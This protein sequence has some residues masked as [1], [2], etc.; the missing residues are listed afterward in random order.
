MSRL[1]LCGGPDPS[2]GDASDVGCVPLAEVVPFAYPADSTSVSTIVLCW[3][4]RRVS[5]RVAEVEA[6]CRDDSHDWC[7]AVEVLVG[8]SSIMGDVEIDFSTS[9]VRST[10]TGVVAVFGFL[11]AG[12]R[13]NHLFF[14]L[15]IIG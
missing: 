11:T 4:D 5:D 14:G 10:T 1:P 7:K 12:L 9:L 3:L 13:I 6:M 15:G 2:I 8:I